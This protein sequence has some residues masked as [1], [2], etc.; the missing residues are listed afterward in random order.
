MRFLRDEGLIETRYTAGFGKAQALRTTALRLTDK[1]M[2]A[3]ESEAQNQRRLLEEQ[4]ALAVDGEFCDSAREVT[5]K[6][7]E[8][9]SG[10]DTADLAIRDA[11][12]PTS[13]DAVG[14]TSRDAVDPIHIKKRSESERSGMPWSLFALRER[15]K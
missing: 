2:E 8:A 3:I 14:P 4:K 6:R 9:R 15:R 13:R 7:N 5:T 12:G 1:A 11:V 10:R